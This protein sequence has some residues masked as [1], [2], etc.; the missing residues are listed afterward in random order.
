MTMDGKKIRREQWEELARKGPELATDGYNACADH[1]AAEPL[2]TWD[3]VKEYLDLGPGERLLDV[4]CGWGKLAVPAAAHGAVSFGVDLSAVMLASARNHAAESATGIHLARS[5]GTALPFRHGAFDVVWCHAVI[6][7]LPKDEARSLVDEIARV[8]KPG[9]RAFL[10]FPNAA[11]PA[12]IASRAASVWAGSGSPLSIHRRSYTIREA[13]N[14][15]GPSL[16]VTRVWAESMQLVP[17][18]IPRGI[19]ERFRDLA[20]GVPDEDC[21]VPI[22]PLT[23]ARGLAVL[24]DHVRR[25]ANTTRPGLVRLSKDFIVE[26]RKS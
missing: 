18:A 5:E 22:L 15:L 23:V 1:P 11:H 20:T 26:A 17:P 24:Y 8:L 25:L 4:G 13:R 10:H 14:F 6:M 16:E 21:L 12:S 19:L 3:W 9:G 2:G 7:H